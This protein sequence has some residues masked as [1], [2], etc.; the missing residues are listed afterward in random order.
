MGFLDQLSGKLSEAGR[1]IKQAGTSAA[2]QTKDFT[3]RTKLN[4]QI[5]QY[6]KDIEAQYTALGRALYKQ[7]PEEAKTFAP[8]IVA[9]IEEASA[10]IKKAQDEILAIS[11]KKICPVCGRQ[12]DAGA[13]FCVGCGTA[14]E[15]DPAMK[16]EEEKKEEE[17]T[18]QETPE[19]EKAPESAAASSDSSSSS[20]SA[21]EHVT[22]E[23]VDD[24]TTK[25]A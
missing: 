18:P 12:N 2:Q 16:Q 5:H 13:K 25:E 15:V 6:E 8:E 17:K 21:P 24:K 22:G 23:V 20:S 14:L 9:K 11:N 1:S 4:A 3:D 10:S 7:K 19:A